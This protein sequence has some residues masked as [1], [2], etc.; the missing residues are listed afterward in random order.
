MNVQ[1]FVFSVVISLFIGL[2]FLRVIKLK[3]REEQEYGKNFV[4]TIMKTS[5]PTIKGQ[6]YI[7]GLG[8]PDIHLN[9]HLQI[10]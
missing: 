10:I 5:V 1:D 7:F 6:N 3:D 9:K 4:C 8:L 2:Q